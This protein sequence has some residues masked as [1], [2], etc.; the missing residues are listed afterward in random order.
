MPWFHFRQNNTGGSFDGPVHVLIEARNA[1]Y[2]NDR[3]LVESPVY[4]DGCDDGFDC[5]CCGDRW[6]R[7]YASEGTEQPKI[8][9]VPLDEYDPNVPLTQWYDSD[10][11][12]VPLEGDSYTIEHKLNKTV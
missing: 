2:A 5:P 4:F 6:Y 9:G 8:Y 3:A 7:A 1:D 12:V 11:L 10:I